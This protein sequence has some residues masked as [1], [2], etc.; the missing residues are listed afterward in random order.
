[1]AR[2]GLRWGVRELA[3]R[4]E[5]SPNTVTR[6][7]GDQP[8]NPATLAA[9]QRAL[10]AAGIE[11]TPDGGVRPKTGSVEAGHATAQ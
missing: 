3:E 8:A 10:E 1:M 4:A 5:V 7:E 9:L 2:A 11:F 6:I